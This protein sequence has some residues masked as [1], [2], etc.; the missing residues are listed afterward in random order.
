[1]QL[2]PNTSAVARFCFYISMVQV[3]GTANSRLGSRST[4]PVVAVLS[5][6]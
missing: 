1:M 3:P 5:T 6:R 2:A 4:A